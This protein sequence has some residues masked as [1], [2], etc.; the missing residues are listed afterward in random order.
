M[1]QK[2]MDHHQYLGCQWILKMKIYKIPTFLAHVMLMALAFEVAS[3]IKGFCFN[4]CIHSKQL[5]I[6][7]NWPSEEALSW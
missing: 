5:V 4:S 1:F 6:I 2:I 7:L 3:A